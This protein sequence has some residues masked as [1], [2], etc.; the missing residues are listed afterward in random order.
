MSR[1]HMHL[2]F[3]PATS[4]LVEIYPE[5]TCSQMQNNAV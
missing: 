2:L 4:L 3:D 1:L 5:D